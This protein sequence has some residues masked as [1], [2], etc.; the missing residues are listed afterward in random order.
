MLCGKG[1]NPR[2][3]PVGYVLEQGHQIRTGA[4][5]RDNAFLQKNEV[6]CRQEA[7]LVA[8]LSKGASAS[9]RL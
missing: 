6:T 7:V 4:K 5:L 8:E 9:L 3:L 2:E 1:D